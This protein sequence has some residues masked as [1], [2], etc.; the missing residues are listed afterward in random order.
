MAEIV[1]RDEVFPKNTDKTYGLMGLMRG[2]S[3]MVDKGPDDT[4]FS[5]PLVF[6]IELVIGL[7]TTLLL[8][9]I[10]LLRDAP[11]EEIANPMVTT[12]PAKAPW[13]F[14]GLQELLEH[15]HPTMAGILIPT[16]LLGFLVILP[17]VD[18]K[19]TGAGRWFTSPRGRRIAALSALYALLVMP[20][21]ILVDNQVNLQELLRDAFP[22]E[23]LFVGQGLLPG[24]FLTFLAFVPALSLFVFRLHPTARD[25]VLAVFTVLFVTAIIFTITGFLFRGP[26]FELNWP[27]NFPDGYNPL[28]TL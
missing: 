19:R 1:S 28:D 7:G 24:L 23:L 8:L 5:F 6:L 25:V 2:E 10:S 3:T 12:N 22:P 11:L 26:N 17:Y 21:Y 27:W 9:I 18:N 15:M 20:T 14:V 13:Y 4:L 16:V